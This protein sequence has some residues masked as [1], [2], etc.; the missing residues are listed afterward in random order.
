MLAVLRGVLLG[1]GS[2]LLDRPV[3]LEHGVID[4]V[5]LALLVLL[6]LTGVPVLHGAVVAGDAAV[7]LGRLAALGA[8]EMLAADVAVVLAD[9]V[10][11]GEV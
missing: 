10:G 11:G 9:G 8:G 4:D 7:D 3:V 1:L 5:F 6:G 2:G